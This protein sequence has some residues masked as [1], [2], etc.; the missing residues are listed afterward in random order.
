[1]EWYVY[2]FAFV[3]KPGARSITI[4]WEHTEWRFVPVHEVK[5]QD[6]VPR[7]DVSLNR[8]VV[9]WFFARVLSDLHTDQKSGASEL[10]TKAVQS[11]LEAL[12]PRAC[13]SLP[14]S[15]VWRTV[16][17]FAWHLAKNGR[18]S[19]GAAITSAVLVALAMLEPKLDRDDTS[20]FV[21]QG[22][23]DLETA[24]RTRQTRMDTI[25]QCFLKTV[26]EH[27]RQL[28]IL[29]ISSSSTIKKCILAL[30]R[31]PSLQRLTLHIPEC[32]PLCEGASFAMSIFAEL[33]DD[34]RALSK[35]H[36]VVAT[37]ASICLLAR[38]ADYVLLGADR[39]SCDGD[40]SNKTG[41]LPAVLAARDGHKDT[42]VLVVSELD[43]VAGRGISHESLIENGNPDE[44]T[45]IWTFEG[46]QRHQLPASRIEV[47]N[48]YFEWVPAKYVD[49]YI[50]DGGAISRDEIQR[51]CEYIQ[52]LEV[53]YFSDL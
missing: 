52:D 15:V 3:L 37:D 49:G 34:P 5:E 4:D 26:L 32:R 24:I 18:P 35:L 31:S 30:A 13:E 14:V 33:K 6:T 46:I 39:L 23:R 53:K 20:Y 47:K 17:L 45:K 48:V 29:T 27:S 1:M 11:L 25:A 19:M 7:L 21:E 38:G 9:P 36:I 50:T 44:V 2:P 42:K 40:V 41:S 12:D 8:A 51:R 43:K 16:R 22:R 10:A 28:C